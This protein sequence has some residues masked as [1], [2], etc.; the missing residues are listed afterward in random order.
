MFQLDKKHQKY[1]R[2]TQTDIDWIGDIPDGWE[3]KKLK[4]DI[5][6]NDGGVWGE[7]P[8]DDISGTIVLR[9]T[10]QEIDGTLYIENPAKRILSKTEIEKS[11]LKK[12]DLLITKSSGSPNHIWKTSWIDDKTARL[13]CCFSNFMQRLR[14][15]RSVS[16]K[17]IA[18]MLNNPK[19]GREQ[20]YY[21]SQT[22]TG[23]ANLNWTLLGEMIF[24]S[25]SFEEQQKIADYL[26]EKTATLDE[27]I[28]QKKKQIELLAEHRTALINNAITKWLDPNVEMKESGIE[29]IWRI[30]AHWQVKPLYSEVRENKKRNEWNGVWNWLNFQFSDSFETYQIVDEWMVIMRLTDLQN[31]KKS[32]RVGYVNELWIITSAYV[33][34]ISKWWIMSSFLYQLLHSY[35]L[36]KVF[37]FLWWWV[38]QGMNYEDLRRLPLLMPPIEEQKQIID[39]LDKETKYIDD[40]IAKIEKSIELLEEYKTSLISHVVSGKIKIT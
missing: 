22:T 26:D 30:P 19:I 27:V 2:Y 20:L 8:I 24:P 40:M 1:A 18:Y 35:D 33:G 12:W 21:L 31:D 16:S 25:P 14:M 7:D 32:L 37:Y 34:L 17:Y 23:L 28:A 5:V 15:K 11:I 3:A 36:Q 39:Y 13:N 4:F 29:W 6:R 10:E 38:R 9:S